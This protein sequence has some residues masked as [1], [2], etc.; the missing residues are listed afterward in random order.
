LP[1]IILLL[2]DAFLPLAWRITNILLVV[3]VIRDGTC[4]RSGLRSGLALGIV[5]AS[6]IGGLFL[7][8]GGEA[9]G[10]IGR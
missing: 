6:T 5:A 9:R 10:R 3:L 7:G 1:V 2:L 8:R 4:K